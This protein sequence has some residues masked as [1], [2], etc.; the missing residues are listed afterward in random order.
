MWF[1][2]IF[3]DRRKFSFQ[4]TSVQ[5]MLLSSNSSFILNG[6]PDQKSNFRYFIFMVKSFKI[7]LKKFRV[8]RKGMSGLPYLKKSAV[9]QYK[10]HLILKHFGPLIEWHYQNSLKPK[11][12]QKPTV[13]YIRWHYK[14]Y[15]LYLIHS[16]VVVWCIA[17]NQFLRRMMLSVK[18]YKTALW[19]CLSY[20]LS[21]CLSYIFW[22]AACT[23]NCS[24]NWSQRG[25]KEHIL[26]GETR[27]GRKTIPRGR[28]RL[29]ARNRRI[30]CFMFWISY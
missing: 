11:W 26:N 4:C 3:H 2:L 23:Q 29:N 20:L 8:P 27:V 6:N 7:Y 14:R 19:D 13:H 18:V 17:L 21:H 12:P 16:K 5:K 1:G 24:K 9:E 10:M 28:A 15:A 25:K 30:S 22:L